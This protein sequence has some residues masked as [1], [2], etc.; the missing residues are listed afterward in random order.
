MNN[1]ISQFLQHRPFGQQHP[2]D[3]DP[4]ERFP[5][6]PIAGEPVRLGVKTE[7]GSLQ[8]RVWAV[9]QSTDDGIQH[10]VPGT[11]VKSDPDFELWSIDLPAFEKGQKI[12]YRV[13]G[14][15]TGWKA[16]TAW[17]DFDVYHWVEFDRI[18]SSDR[19][20][21][22]VRV[23]FGRT[24]S[25]AGIQVKIDQQSG[26]TLD[27]RCSLVQVAESTVILNETQKF[28]LDHLNLIVNATTACVSFMHSEG[29]FEL[30]S[31]RAMRALL[32]TNGNARRYEL[33]FESPQGESFYGFGERYNTI[34]QR[35][36]SLRNRVID[37]YKRQG[38]RTYYPVPFF[39]SSRG[40]GI[41][42][43]T[44]HEVT[45]DLA[46]SDA[47]AWKM[48]F[49]AGSSST[50]LEF[51]LMP[52]GTPT[53]IIQEFTRL[54]GR[55]KMPPSWVFGLWMSSNDWNS[56]AEVMRQFALT[57]K[58][59]IPVT[60]LVIEAW[61]DEVNFYI[62]NDARY[63][64][65]P[66]GAAFKY[67]DFAFPEE[68][69]WPDPKGMIDSL[70]AGGTRLILWQ[71]PVLKHCTPDEHLDER[72]NK[73]DEQYWMDNQLCAMEEN[74]EPYRVLSPWFKGSL[75]PD[76]TNP[77]TV[78][79]W[80]KQ[81]E[82][83]MKEMGVDG[84][85]TDGSEHIWSDTVH[86]ADGTTG[87]GRCNSFATLYLGAYDRFLESTR[88]TD[89]FLFSRAGYTGSQNHP[90]HWAGDEDS[91]WEAF[92]SN[93]NAMLNLSLSGEPFVG[94][95]MAGFG[96]DPPG[97]ELYLRSAAMAVFCP[98]MQYHSEYNARQIPSR[99][100]TPWNI[101]DRSGDER[102]I[103]VFRR[104][105]RVRMNLI[106]YIQS[107]AWLSTQTGLPM[108][109]PLQVEFP[110]EGTDGKAVYE[111]MFGQ[112]LLVAPVVEEGNSRWQVSLPAGKWRDLWT[113][114]GVEGSQTLTVD[115]PLGSIPVYQREGTILPL[116]LDEDFELGSDVGNDTESY[117]NLELRIF[118]GQGCAL[119]LVRRQG[120][121]I[122]H[123]SVIP[124]E[125]DHQ[126]EMDLPA[127]GCAVRVVVYTSKPST[128][129]LDDSPVEWHWSDEQQI[130]AVVVGSTDSKHKLVIR[131]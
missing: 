92:R 26:G 78:E 34:D 57:Q 35:G 11:W 14:E 119:D 111:Y 109:S 28:H 3:Q 89:R 82:Y 55:A 80:F 77:H 127:L 30:K 112:S 87:E 84:F 81:R 107:Q 113:H 48:E 33:A 63:E 9:W 124:N 100:R 86:F 68:G 51:T 90:G 38:K 64:L 121:R 110:G 50:D 123:I 58:H 72:Q 99:D 47:A 108:I 8:G 5:R 76:F 128:V 22:A 23:L 24:G 21:G 98:I 130:L 44:D 129:T 42:V 2:Y 115:V 97:A 45:F 20:G 118:P 40:Y 62:W 70:H 46:E 56:Q 7:P 95:D 17:F 74:G 31:T 94:W 116:N 15:N 61:A 6:Q 54:T 37:Q 102:V 73:I 16:E 105:T 88:G 13:L 59:G 101:Q 66:G 67:S 69:H 18:L 122:D 19:N 117:R 114:T 39:I 85:K 1:N 96:N 32:D 53:G 27:I 75:L 25:E 120:E 36:N 103:P 79:W 106:P 4:E 125:N 91:N 126:I 29:K 131:G 41:W 93:L 43:K 83:L 12:R 104:L 65:K 52:Q 60:V 49:Q 10:S 71:I